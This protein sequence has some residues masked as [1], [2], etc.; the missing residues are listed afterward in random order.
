MSQD[1]R[2]VTL[3]SLETQSGRFSLLVG[4]GLAPVS[5]EVTAPSGRGC[6]L[7]PLELKPRGQR[8]RLEFH[9]SKDVASESGV[10]Q[11][12]WT[13]EQ[14]LQEEQAPGNSVWAPWWAGTET[15]STFSRVQGALSPATVQDLVVLQVTAMCYSWLLQSLL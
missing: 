15:I 1:L 9:N 5:L 14:S 2:A 12:P 13:T 4:D 10:T 11:L 8:A 3:L 6:E 7:E